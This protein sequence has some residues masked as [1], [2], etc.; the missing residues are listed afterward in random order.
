MKFM[1][2]GKPDT[3]QAKGG[4]NVRVE[5]YNKK[6]SVVDRRHL[7]W[8]NKMDDFLVDMFLEEKLK[9]QKI[10]GIFAKSAYREAERAVSNMFNL[11]CNSAHVK[12]QVKTLKKH[13][14]DDVL[15]LSG[16]GFN[17]LLV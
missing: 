14:V 7:I 16:F 10:S 2:L 8:S 9:G 13:L 11:S 15:K 12:N 1:K 3:F 6:S 5:D 17:C 4:N